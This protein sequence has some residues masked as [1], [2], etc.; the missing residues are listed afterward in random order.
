MW[1]M[2]VPNTKVIWPPW[3]RVR[4]ASREFLSDLERGK[5]SGHSGNR[6]ACVMFLLRRF[7]VAMRYVDVGV[8]ADS[9]EFIYKKAS[10]SRGH[11]ERIFLGA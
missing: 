10:R 11:L 2:R 1:S 5:E 3:G 4:E 7:Q 8:G 6:L 9:A